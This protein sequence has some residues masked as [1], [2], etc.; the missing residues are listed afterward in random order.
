MKKFVL[1]VLYITLFF[2][3]PTYA[4]V[5]IDLT[6]GGGIKLGSSSTTCNAA[7]AGVI[8][9]TS[10]ESSLNSADRASFSSGPGAGSWYGTNKYSDYPVRCA[11]QD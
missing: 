2:T 6:N 3:I 5:G 1:G 10:S 7:A 9:W 8:Y 4:Q 11:R